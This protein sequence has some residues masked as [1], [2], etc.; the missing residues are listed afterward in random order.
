MRSSPFFSFLNL[1][2][3]VLFSTFCSCKKPEP[4]R[5]TIEGTISDA[6]G[7]VSD[8]EIQLAVKEISS[9]TYSNNFVVFHTTNSNALGKYLH[10]F[11]AYNAIEYKIDVVG[12]N[13]FSESLVFDSDELQKNETNTYDFY[14]QPKAWYKV[15]IKNTSP[16]DSSDL[17]QYQITSSQPICSSC[18]GNTISVL[19]GD[20]V[21]TSLKCLTLGNTTL[22]IGWVVTKN[23]FTNSYSNSITCNTGDTAVYY[24]NY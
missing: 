17:L 2:I 13:R 6:T 20:T 4:A 7:A 10:D 8:A 24:L 3:I 14:L 1:F 23:G 5:I 18:C 12:Q 16:V 9:G 15:I 11:E 22:D 19:I 21:N